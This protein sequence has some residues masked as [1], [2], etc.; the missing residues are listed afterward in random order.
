MVIV[1]GD[2][3]TILCGLDMFLSDGVHVEHKVFNT[4][5]FTTRHRNASTFCIKDRS[6]GL[7]CLQ[8]VAVSCLALSFVVQLKTLHR[9]SALKIYTVYMNIKK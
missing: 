9:G 2:A 8:L 3:I 4:V 5:G 6:L 7:W 1:M